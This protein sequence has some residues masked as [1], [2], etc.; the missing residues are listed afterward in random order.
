MICPCIE[1]IIGLPWN[2]RQMQLI[3]LY[4]QLSLNNALLDKIDDVKYCKYLS[5]WTQQTKDWINFLP[6]CLKKKL[7]KK[8]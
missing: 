3:Q 7:W 8:K 1:K 5:K 2:E 4:Y 6:K